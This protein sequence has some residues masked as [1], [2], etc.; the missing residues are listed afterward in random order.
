MSRRIAYLDESEPY[1]ERHLGTY[2]LAA[3][4][5]PTEEHNTARAS[6][7]ALKPRSLSKAHWHQQPDPRDRLQ[8]V[9]TVAAVPGSQL[10]VV[11]LGD[12][13]DRPERRRRLCME[14]MA[15][16]LGQL[17]VQDAVIE[18]RGP[19]DDARDRAM[20]QALRQ[21]RALV[22]P[23]RFEHVAG[24]AEPLL[25]APDVICGAVNESRAGNETYVSLLPTLR[26][27]II[28]AR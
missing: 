2:V 23:L 7:A 16:E 28:D 9:R 17:G 26:T 25:W 4:I 6:M 24:P 27:V 19:A 11:R 5:I 22:S 12:A 8:L 14:R 3:A 21:R 18:S 10:V 15:Y 20:L 1:H 13:D